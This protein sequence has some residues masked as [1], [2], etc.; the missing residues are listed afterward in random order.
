MHGQFIPYYG[1]SKYG[2][3]GTTPVS[4]RYVSKSFLDSVETRSRGR[5]R[6]LTQ[7]MPVFK[8]KSSGW[9]SESREWG[10]ERKWGSERRVSWS[11]YPSG[12]QGSGY[13][14]GDQGQQQ[15]RPEVPQSCFGFL[16]RV[17]YS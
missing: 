8:M 1:Q 17:F 10:S 6:A 2:G 14:Q 5:D 16:Y 15:S 3:P 13:N 11:D 9:S 7:L 4:T 12:A